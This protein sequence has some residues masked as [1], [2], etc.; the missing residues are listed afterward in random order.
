[1]ITL[2]Y[3]LVIEATGDP[4]FF[5]FFSPELEGFSGTG[6]SLDDC[7][8]RAAEGMDEHIRLLREQELP[9]PPINPNPRVT[10]QNTQPLAPASRY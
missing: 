6:Q 3:S 4:C 10:V 2:S 9:V 8:E 1:M 5:A 7:L